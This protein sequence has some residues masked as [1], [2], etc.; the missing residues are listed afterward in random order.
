MGLTY[1]KEAQLRKMPIIQNRLFK[2]KSGKLIVHQTII[3][4]VKPVAYYQTILDKK[5]S[6]AD[7]DKELEEYLEK[8]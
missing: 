5:K 4:H 7:L 3:T 8:V 2:S 1:K 6:I